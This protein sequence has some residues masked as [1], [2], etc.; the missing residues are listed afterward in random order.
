MTPGPGVVSPVA[1]NEH[2]FLNQVT[3]NIQHEFHANGAPMTSNQSTVP[4]VGIQ[5]VSS[6]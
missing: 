6:K 4:P 2:G 3:P 5:P 1:S